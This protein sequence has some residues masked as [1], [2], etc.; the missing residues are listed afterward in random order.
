MGFRKDRSA[1]S[2]RGLAEVA[3]QEESRIGVQRWSF[4][5]AIWVQLIVVVI[6]FVAGWNLGWVEGTALA[7][8]CLV[9][10][11]V[12]ALM[13]VGRS[14]YR[15]ELGLGENQV[16]V[17][18]RA[19]GRVDI[20]NVGKRGVWPSTLELPV[21][22]GRAEFSLPFLGPGRA[23]DELFAV[24][25][26]KR[27]VI[28]VGPVK[29][30]RTD[31]LGL[32]RREIVWTKQEKLFVH[33]E[34]VH[35]KGAAAGVMRDLEGQTLRTVTDNDMSFHALREYV[36]GDD[37]RSIHWKSSARNQSLMVRQFEDTRRTHTAL[38]IDIDPTS[39]TDDDAFELGVS[40]FA[41]M[42]INTIRSEMDR[43]FL[44]DDVHARTTSPRAFLDETSAI[45]L[46]PAGR[47]VMNVAERVAR[48]AADC[49]LAV[50]VTGLVPGL[51]ELR[52]GAS[53]LPSGVRTLYI[54]CAPGEVNSVVTHG[55]ISFARLGDLNELGRVL[56]LAV[57]A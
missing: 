47:P 48:E 28:M 44:V 57:S 13:T 33:P 34:T 7:V 45:S 38:A 32:V 29:S 1:T 14:T 8:F 50:L 15:V 23:H 56:R 55:Q 21:G 53:R 39:W 43:T 16:R 52:E 35:L 19:F 11:T 36:P 24:P 54:Q 42:G 40:V 51:T 26:K 10:P 12:S 6:A 18:E 2:R 5:P 22:G 41:S 3:L 37:R 30:V 4:A 17:G 46:A 25:T 20:E 9:V 31:P 49:S 27:A